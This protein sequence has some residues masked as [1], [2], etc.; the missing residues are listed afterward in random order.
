[1]DTKDLIEQTARAFEEFKKAND[2]RLDK[3][4]KAGATGDLDAKLAKIEE[5]LSTALGLKAELARIEA[6]SNLQG[7]FSGDKPEKTAYKSAFFDRFVR[8]GEDSAELK[9]LMR[10]AWS[11]GTPADGGYALPEELDR[12]IEKM[13]RD[14]SPVR[15]V[16]NVVQVGTSDY[17]KLVN[18]N[19]IASGWVG[20]TAARPATNTSQFAEVA[21]PMGEV[22]A[23]PQVTQ[24]SLDDM[25]F[26][27]EQEL[28]DQLM[29]EF[30]VAEGA[31]FVSGNGTNK[32]K[33]FLAYTTAATADSSRAFGTIEHVA[34]GVAGDFAA[35]NNADILFTLV[36][37]LKQGYRAGSVWMM[38]KGLLFEILKFKDTSGQYLWQP[39]LQAS[40]ISL[41][42][43]GFPVVEAEDM[44]A[45]AADALAIA[46][47]NFR[48][49]YTVVDRMGIRMLRDPY[50][51]KPYVGF[52]TTKRVGGAVV[53]S[54]AIKVAKFALA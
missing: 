10:K 9:D 46:F 21:P 42:L 22:Y 25:F 4:E 53:N 11:I 40:G 20:E 28:Q 39:S 15:S 34:T 17:K 50:S 3:I 24:H 27:V 30:A 8:K 51:N 41:N 49:A 13:L 2:A 14:V 29:E 47:G 36:S 48:R 1:M 45:K 12:T 16:A 38:N 18:V 7:L 19:G 43:L 33:G 35:S 32:P 37:K 6:K 52:Y 26:N 54:E 23:N 44:P 31:A 5:D